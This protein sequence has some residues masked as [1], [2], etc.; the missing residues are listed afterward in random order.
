M[1]YNLAID[2]GSVYTC[3]YKVGSGLV[4]KEPTLISA[5]NKDDEYQIVAMGEEAKKMQGKTD[6]NTYIFSPISEGKI[7]SFEYAEVLI[8]YFLD[9]TIIGNIR[10]FPSPVGSFWKE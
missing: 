6:E 3:I 9:K 2:F 5:E 7:K 8:N 4:L 10:S 1:K